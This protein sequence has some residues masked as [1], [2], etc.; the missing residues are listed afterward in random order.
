MSSNSISN[1]GLQIQSLAGLQ[2]QQATL[3]LLD[4]Q[5]AS[6]T[7]YDNLTNYDPTTAKNLMD[8]QN[9]V[10]QNQAYI[11]GMQTVSTRLNLYDQTMTDMEGIAENAQ[12]VAANN[13]T[14]DPSSVAQ[15]QSQ[16][17]SY[18][19]Q[20]TSDL[21]EQIGGRY[22]YAG[23]RY[24]TAPV[25]DLSTLTTAP[26]IPFTPVTSP[27]LP[28]YDSQY[29]AVTMNNVPASGNFQVGNSKIS[30]SSI[31]AGNVTSVDVNGTPTAVTV[32]GLTQPATTPAEV[33]SNL[34][35]TINQVSSQISDFSGLSAT[36]DGATV[37]LTASAVAQ[38]P[39][40]TVNSAPTGDFQVGGA[41]IAWSAIESGTVSSITVNGV[42]TPVTVN[43]LTQPATTPTQIAANLAST[44]NQL[45]TQVSQFSGLSATASGA[46]VNFYATPNTPAINPDEGGVPSE[47]T[48]SAGTS[49]TA[50]IPDQG[51]TSGD[52]SWSSGTDGT[53]SQTIASSAGAYTEDSVAIDSST[54]VTYGVTSNNP[55]IQQLVAGLQFLNAATQ[56]GVSASSYKTDMAQANTLLTT[57]LSGIQALNAGVASNQNILDTETS[58]QNADITNL[59]NQLSNLQSVNL[60]QVGTEINTMQTQLQASYSATA[61]LEQ[62]SI[63]KY[64]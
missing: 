48:W 60:T 55:A 5:L 36:V 47:I 17:Q 63:L 23:S 8:F 29:T 62:L 6:G 41:S 4:Q 30:W 9:S 32:T 43:G 57:A 64:L 45:S 22:I 50:I 15:L 49:G 46:G 27:T 40:L 10:T 31:V 26:S 42:S 19:E 24:T 3:A 18:L 38:Q 7:I 58:T 33:A 44:I 54:S 61:A 21:N 35:A 1:I 28:D 20:L 11:S 39:S 13:Q 16:A 52:T 12:Q 34:Q 56:S 2:T 25:I 51:G 53:S 59:Q 37:S 14:L